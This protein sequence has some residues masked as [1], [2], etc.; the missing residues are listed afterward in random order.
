MIHGGYSYGATTVEDADSHLHPEATRDSTKFCMYKAMA[1]VHGEPWS[2][3]TKYVE[4]T[5][6]LRRIFFVPFDDDVWG[7]M[8]AYLYDC[9]YKG[10]Y[11]TYSTFETALK[12]E[13][14]QV[15]YVSIL[16]SSSEK[17]GHAIC[18]KSNKDKVLEFIDNESSSKDAIAS[19]FKAACFSFLVF[20]KVGGVG[21]S[22]AQAMAYHIANMPETMVETMVIAKGSYATKK[23]EGRTPEDIRTDEQARKMLEK[24]QKQ[25][26]LV[27]AASHIGD[28]ASKT[29]SGFDT[30]MPK[31]T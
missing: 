16:S 14:G 12:A 11:D 3:Y 21:G 26:S 5:K 13:A 29:I 20:K 27:K 25:P 17:S 24:L 1:A 7:V 23:I 18:V 10:L 30:A 4:A 22:T 9:H 15:Y 6:P 2:M 8:L 31:T 19:K 28:G